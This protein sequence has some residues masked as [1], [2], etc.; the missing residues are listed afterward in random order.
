M[1][2]ESNIVLIGMPAVGKSTVGVLLAKQSGLSF[3]DTDIHIQTHEGRS[4]QQIIQKEGLDRF[5]AIEEHHI[6]SLTCTSHVIAT[7]GSVVYSPAAMDHLK[8]SGI[9]VF[10]DL[11]PA[12]LK[13]RLKDI[14]GR[15]VLRMPGQT[16]EMLYQERIPLYRRHQNI[17]IACDGLTPDQVVSRILECP[18]PT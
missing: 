9:V 3:L 16:I 8:S 1:A 15:G 17:T 7:G 18:L 13:S 11:S 12:P 2:P 5:K 14:D 4:L 6:R 10:L